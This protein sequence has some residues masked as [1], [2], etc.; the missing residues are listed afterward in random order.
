MIKNDIALTIEKNSEFNGAKSLQIVEAILDALKEAL[1]RK[2]KIEIRGFGSFKV[3]AKKTGYGRDI[4]RKKQ[5]HIAEG[6]R[7][8]FRSGQDLK[9][10]ILKQSS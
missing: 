6:K 10:L 3:V 5:I 9:N 2:E 1:V 4:R 8:K 7:V